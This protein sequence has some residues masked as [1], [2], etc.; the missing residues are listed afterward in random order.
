MRQTPGFEQHHEIGS[1]GKRFP[2]AG[3]V[4]DQRER[5]GE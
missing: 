1:T 3:L 2:N 4:A 5:I